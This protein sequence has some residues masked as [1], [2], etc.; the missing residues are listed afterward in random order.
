MLKPVFFARIVAQWQ[1]AGYI[2]IKSPEI[3][4]FIEDFQGID[5]ENLRAS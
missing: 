4:H 2:R 3:S 5:S 1:F